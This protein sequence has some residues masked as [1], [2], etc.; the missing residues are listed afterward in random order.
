[1][2]MTKYLY[3]ITNGLG[4]FYVVAEDVNSAAALLTEELDKSKCGYS[5]DRIITDIKII[6]SEDYYYSGERRF[7]VEPY[8]PLLIQE[9]N[10]Q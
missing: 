7:Y 9:S 10:E 5:E 4:K 3:E 2:Y 1:M 8:K 6:A